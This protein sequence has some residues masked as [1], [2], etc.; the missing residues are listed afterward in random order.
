MKDTH[1]QA[2]QLIK[3]GEWD[4][5]HH[6]VQDYSDPF[7]CHIHAYLHRIEG[8]LANANYWYRRAGLD[9]SDKAQDQEL[10]D[11]FTLLSKSTD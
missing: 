10:I 2:L 5:A 9:M 7:S 6:L 1:L 3:K 4:S 11:L 8:D